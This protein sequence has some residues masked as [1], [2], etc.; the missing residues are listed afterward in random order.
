[1]KTEND[2]LKIA[3][4]IGNAK[5]G[6]V[7]SC[8]LNFY[9]HI[10]RTKFQFDFFTYGESP[11][12]EEI[13][14]LGGRVF[15]FSDTHNFVK[16]Y[17]DLRRYFSLENYYAVHA[18][19]TS[20]SF[21]P[22]LAAKSRGIKHR[23]CHAHSTTHIKD[24]NWII[25]NILKRLSKMSASR[26]AGCSLYSSGWLYGEKDSYYAFL[27]HNAIDLKRFGF[28]EKK[29]EELA[30]K[31]NLGGKKIIGS[32]GRLVFQKNYGFL[33]DAFYHLSKKKSD[34]DLVIV[35]DG[36]E[37]EKLLA[38]IQK[39]NLQQ[40]VHI[41]PDIKNVEEYYKI[42]DLFVLTSRFEGLPLVAVEAQAVGVPCLLSSEITKEVELGG[43]CEF[44]PIKESKIWAD[45][46]LNMLESTYR[47][48]AT[49]EIIDAGYEIT[50]ESVKLMQF[51]SSLED[52]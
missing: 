24:K 44:L 52:R 51:Y 1:M 7:I 17:F 16:A 10:D 45:K 30:K 32:I 6:G 48:D 28:V 49:S 5:S 50:T 19:M 21:V 8:V 2:I 31:Y 34:V 9:R 35:G 22:L 27:L 40:R 47:Y 13:R 12:D 3:Q 18:H 33:I 38:K 46:M 26:M 20:L 39:L 15:Y 42:F 36:K 29:D 37:K 4:V 41:L 25:K 11:Y 43:K 23:I 14:S